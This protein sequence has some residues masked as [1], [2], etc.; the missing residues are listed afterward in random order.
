METKSTILKN[1]KIYSDEQ[2]KIASQHQVRL[3]MWKR[4]LNSRKT[5]NVMLKSRL[6]N[7]LKNNYTQNSLEEI[8]D[9]QTRFVTEDEM[10]DLLRK[11]V[12]ELI[13]LQYRDE[14]GNSNTEATWINIMNR[15]SKQIAISTARFNKLNTAF[16]EFR[17]KLNQ[18][19]RIKS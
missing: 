3:E 6:A 12:D 13:R 10:I 5:E 18:D 9:F 7:I 16:D 19:A 11:E 17:Q 15:L 2:N 1:N 14:L 4:L 8:E